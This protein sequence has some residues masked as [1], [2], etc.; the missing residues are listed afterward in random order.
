MNEMDFK[1]YLAFLRDLGVTLGEITTVEQEKAKFV[2]MDDLDGLNECMKREQALSMTLRSCDQKRDAMLLLLGLEG[3]PL[4]DLLDHAPPEDREETRKTVEQ[5]CRQ[6]ALFRSAFEVAQDTLECNL[7]Q[8][9]KVLHMESS[10]GDMQPGYQETA[11][12]LPPR[13]R[14][15]F[16][17]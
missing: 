1:E 3:V 9:E 6:Y 16:R 14:T 5:L 11:P 10:D 12:Q 8:I 15:D 4:R 2:R 13:L 7:H 17:A